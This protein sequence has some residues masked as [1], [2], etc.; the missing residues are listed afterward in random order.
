M[1]E[2]DDRP[3]RRPLLRGLLASSLAVAVATG[4]PLAPAEAPVPGVEVETI[5]LVGPVDDAV[6]VIAR[7]DADAGAPT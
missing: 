7:A 4:I 2:T 6:A 5:E 3:R 1:G